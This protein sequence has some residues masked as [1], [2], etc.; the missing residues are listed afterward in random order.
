[1]AAQKKIVP[2]ISTSHGI[3]ARRLRRELENLYARQEVVDDLI[4]SL[5]RYHRYR[6]KSVDERELRSA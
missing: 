6:A 3:P 2:L 5:E 1:M 4:D